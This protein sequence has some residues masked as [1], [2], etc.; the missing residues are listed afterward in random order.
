MTNDFE[1]EDDEFRPEPDFP[2]T[3]T[4]AGIIW[5][6]IGGLSILQLLLMLVLPAAMPQAKARPADQ[7][8][9]NVQ[10][11]AKGVG[12]CCGSLIGGAF[13]FVGAQSVRGTANDT[14]GNGIGSIVLGILQLAYSAIAALVRVSFLDL[15]IGC[16]LGI[17]LLV[18]GVI[19]L[20]GRSDYKAWRESQMP[21]RRRKRRR[22]P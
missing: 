16:I 18:A 13:I 12:L 20:L 7:G 6:V 11:V 15:A 4:V 5:I 17:G 1:D 10:R 14:L 22:R 9:E 3:V 8:Q 2:A 21:R 19:A